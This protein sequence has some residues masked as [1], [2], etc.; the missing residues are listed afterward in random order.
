MQEPVE[1]GGE[2]SPFNRA[3]DGS[4][5]TGAATRWHQAPSGPG[6]ACRVGADMLEE[7]ELAADRS[8]RRIS[9]AVVASAWPCGAAKR[10]HCAGHVVPCGC[11]LGRPPGPDRLRKPANGNRRRPDDRTPALRSLISDGVRTDE[12]QHAGVELCGVAG[13]HVVGCPGDGHPVRIRDQLGQAVGDC[14][15]VCW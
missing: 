8:T 2:P 5:R 13:E 6:R 3:R 15:K 10:A 1:P 11:A 4:R 12:A 9:K 7:A 14:L